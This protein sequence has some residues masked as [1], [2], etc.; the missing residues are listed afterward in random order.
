MKLTIRLKL[1]TGFFLIVALLVGLGVASYRQLQ[2]ASS[3]V[4]FL[5]A[6]TI[7]SV[8]TVDSIGLSANDFRRIQLQH[9]LTYSQSEMA[10]DEKAIEVDRTNIENLFKTYQENLLNNQTEEALLQDTYKLWQ[11][12]QDQTKDFA[13]ISRNL[14]KSSSRDLLTGDARKTF[15]A[16]LT[17]L[18]EWRSLNTDQAQTY[19]IEMQKDFST[20]LW[21][22]ALAVG[23]AVVFAAGLALFLSGSISKGV[24]QMVSAANQINQTDLA[25][26]EAVVTRMAAGDLTQRLHMQTETLRYHATDELGDLANTFNQMIEHLQQT[27][28]SFDQMLATIREALGEVAVNANS[29]NEASAQLAVTA[30]QSGMAA[31]QIAV[32]IQ[33]VAKGA[34]QQTQSISQTAGAIEQMSRAIG[35]VAQGAQEQAGA[36]ERAAQVTDQL[37]HAID[38]V[39]QT[40]QQQA[41][42]AAE[43]VQ[44]T[45]NGAATVD[46]TVQGMTR[47]RARVSQSAEKVQQMG[48]R[49]DQIGMIVET[50]DDIASQTNLLALN[51]AIEAARAGEHGKGFAVVADEVRKLAERSSTATK[52]IGGLIHEIQQTLGEAV[53][54]MTE[55][56]AEV[57]SGMNLANQSG[58]SLAQMLQGAEKSRQSGAAITTAAEHM[59]R[60]ATELVSAMDSVSAVVEENTA[61]TEEMSAGSSSVTQSIENI[62]SVSEENSASVEEASAGA[63]EMSAQVAEVTASAQSL[64][65]MANTLQ[66]LVARFKLEA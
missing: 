61:A 40:A 10:D 33:Q 16:M 8:S 7:P 26:L 64:S 22:F 2:S 11:Q 46:Q 52:E 62:A 23:L 32:T 36:V 48:Q 42:N 12:Y 45:Q 41:L 51:A 29:L 50:I 15:E 59:N 35:G 43:A 3:R 44:S 18:D 55:S 31:E 56:A 6:N 58:A 13:A 4:Q 66:T 14:D 19:A 21:N 37:S 9:V 27:G 25:A 65:A 53:R 47:I 5:N 57:E 38:E 20:F 1:I 49:S 17:K 60:L 54:A 24:R 34:S 63:E 39:F 30:A 28:K